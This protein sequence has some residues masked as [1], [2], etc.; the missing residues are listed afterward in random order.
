MFTVFTSRGPV[1]DHQ[2]S[3]GYNPK[4]YYEA[5]KK[6]SRSD[7]TTAFRRRENMIPADL[8]RYLSIAI[9]II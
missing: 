4:T 6:L 7:V 5:Y 3:F 1:A 8:A 9:D 2:K